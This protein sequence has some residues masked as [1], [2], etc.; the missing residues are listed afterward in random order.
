MTRI[1]PT[2]IIEDGAEIG[3]DVTIWHHCHVRATAKVCDRVSLGRDV[4]VD[5]GVTIREGS[6]IQNSVNVYAGV[7]IG[8]WAF[9]GPAVVFTNDRYPRAGTRSWQPVS[10]FVHAGAAI[11]AGAIITCGVTVGAFAMVGAGTV[12]T[13]SVPPFHLA[14]GFGSG[15]KA[16]KMLC[17][18]GE[19]QMPL[20]TRPAELLRD[21]CH[22][23]L[24]PE[25]VALARAV[26]TENHPGDSA[27]GAN[28]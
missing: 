16:N 18:C 27:S 13:H 6:R 26:I 19:T 4:Y 28:T 20:G 9:I 21:C 14:V 23:K 1:H 10:T 8:P 22:E 12:L 2:A 11:G 3:R 25:V 5:P 15:V 7:E 17:S 24:E